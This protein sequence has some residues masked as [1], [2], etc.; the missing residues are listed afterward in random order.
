V[1]MPVRE[2]EQWVRRQHKGRFPGLFDGL[3]DAC[4]LS[5]EAEAFSSA[6]E[7]SAAPWLEEQPSVL[8]LPQVF[9]GVPFD[10]MRRSLET[11]WGV[12]IDDARRE[13]D[14]LFCVMHIAD[15]HIWNTMPAQPQRATFLSQNRGTIYEALIDPT[16]QRS[17]YRAVALG[18]PKIWNHDAPQEA[19][20]QAMARVWADNTPQIQIQRIYDGFHLGVKLARARKRY[21]FFPYHSTR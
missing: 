6:A 3:F 8:L 12:R 16:T 10:A 4:G 5:S 17:T 14:G 11:E 7:S 19:A 1:W 15:P 9:E 13:C 2:L 18:L 21:S 20:S